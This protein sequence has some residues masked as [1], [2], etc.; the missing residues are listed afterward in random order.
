VSSW[1]AGRYVEGKGLPTLRTYSAIA[2]V[3]VVFGWAG[4]V[5]AP[6]ASAQT[7]NVN[8]VAQVA[9]IGATSSGFH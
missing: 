8:L 2:F 7:V 3:A 9:Y 1:R 5:T 4:M 6:S